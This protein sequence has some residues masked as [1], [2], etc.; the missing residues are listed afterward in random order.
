MKKLVFLISFVLLSSS[1]INGIAQSTLSPGLDIL[2]YGYDVFG[3]YADQKSKKKYCLFNYDNYSESPIG[4]DLYKVP[5][6]VVLENI[7]DHIIKT[8]K[9]SSIRD[10]SSSLSKSAGLGYDAMFFSASINTTYSEST[11]G[12]E[13]KFYFTYMDANTKWRIS[14]D[15]RSI[16]NLKSI[17]DPQFKRI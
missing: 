1:W 17:L 12:S 8:V 11:S 4:S 10:Y 13:R 2:G 16:S 7:S 3:K 14:F 15:E 5:Q 6:Y 9:G